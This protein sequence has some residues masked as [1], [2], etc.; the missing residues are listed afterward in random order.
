MRRLVGWVRAYHHPQ[1]RAPF[2]FMT[3][4]GHWGVRVMFKVKGRKRVSMYRKGSR[5]TGKRM[6]YRIG[7]YSQ[8]LI[9]FYR[10]ISGVSSPLAAVKGT[11]SAASFSTTDLSSLTR[12]VNFSFSAFAYQYMCGHT[13]TQKSTLKE[14][15]TM[16][17]YACAWVESPKKKHTH[18]WCN[19]IH[20]N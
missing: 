13:N 6:P 3:Y 5:Y 17:V 15:R 19:I 9:I 1:E 2:Y 4:D 10:T 12:K 16:R 8:S 18:K 20:N 14:S 7:V 11:T